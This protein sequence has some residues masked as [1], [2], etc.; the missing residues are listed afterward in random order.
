M[1]GKGRVLLP[2]LLRSGL[3]VVGA[4]FLLSSGGLLYRTFG[5]Q[6]PAWGLACYAWAG[7]LL[8]SGIARVYLS[9]PW[10]Y[11]AGIALS[12]LGLG[13]LAFGG[14]YGIP[15]AGDALLRYLGVGAPAAQEV[16]PLLGHL[17]RLAPW[18]MGLTLLLGA[19][20]AAQPWLTRFP[21]PDAEDGARS[22]LQDPAQ[23]LK[24]SALL[25]G[26][27]FYL[28]HADGLVLAWTGS[29]VGSLQAPAY[30]YAVAQVMAQGVAYVGRG[31]WR[32]AVTA[33]IRGYSLLL[34]TA[35]LLG[36][37]PRLLGDMG[38]GTLLA[39]ALR[40][41]GPYLLHLA[42]LG[43]WA[44]GYLGLVTSYRVL[45]ALL[46]TPGRPALYAR[47]GRDR[48][49]P[50]PALRRAALTSAAAFLT[51]HPGGFLSLG[52]GVD[53]SFLKPRVYGAAGL[54]L[55]SGWA[56]LLSLREWTRVPRVLFSSGAWG[57]LTYALLNDLPGIAERIGA[58]PGLAGLAR[59]LAPYAAHTAT[60]DLWATA[61]ILVV[62]VYRAAE[63]YVV[64]RLE[65]AAPTRPKKITA[66]SG[67]LLLRPQRLAIASPVKALV[68][69]ALRAAGVYLLLPSEGYLDLAWGL[70]LGFLQ[71]PLYVFLA[72][73]LAGGMSSFFGRRLWRYAS[74][75]ALQGVAWGQLWF[76][77]LRDIPSVLEALARS[78]S[79]APLG[80][81]LGPYLG[82]LTPLAPWALAYVL[83]T[84]AYCATALYWNR[85]AF[86][87][88]Y[89]RLG[90]QEDAPVRALATS[91]LAAVSTY[92][93]LSPSGL[94][95]L[96]YGL[97]FSFLAA[98]LY[99]ATAVLLLAR[100]VHILGSGLWKVALAEFFTWS[101]LAG[102][103]YF[104]F[105]SLGRIGA[106]LS[107][108]PPFTLAGEAALPY[109]AAVQR[110]D[111]WA[112]GGLE[113]LAVYRG[114]AVYWSQPQYAQFRPLVQA[115][116]FLLL[117]GMVWGAFV[118][119]AALGPL[120]PGLGAIAFGA[121][122]AVA[123]GHLARYAAGVSDPLA[124]ALGGWASASAFRNANVGAFLVL[125]A[126][127]LRRALYSA[128]LYAPLLEWVVVAAIC[129]Y[130]IRRTHK[131]LASQDARPP[132]PPAWP[133]W[134]RHHQEV[135]AVPDAPLQNALRAQEL[136]LQEGFPVGLIVRLI[137]ALG[138]NGVPPER[139]TAVI[140]P[141]ADYGEP[142]FNPLW[143]L[144]VRLHPHGR[145]K[146]ARRVAEHRAA[147]YRRVQ[148][149]LEEALT[150]ARYA[151]PFPGSNGDEFR[152]QA[153]ASFIGGDQKAGL[154]TV[155]ALESWRRGA[156]RG[157]MDLLLLPVLVYQDA[158]VPWYALPWTRL[159][160]AG[161][162]VSQ[163]QALVDTLRAHRERQGLL[164]VLTGQTA[165]ETPQSSREATERAGV[166]T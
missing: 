78:P 163:R 98:P 66:L 99:A 5:V 51:F 81:A 29:Y 141:L 49:R 53:L 142:R 65:T 59:T 26:L 17:S 140:G 48:E 15:A 67:I 95:H 162:I 28:F 18:V 136:F 24:Q 13:M 71:G 27:A 2:G 139:I 101:A 31:P 62:A 91:A 86:R 42:R 150:D 96:W 143:L 63:P 122:A 166:T 102:L 133:T 129:L 111:L 119:L 148:R 20:R 112:G 46:V 47:L 132:L 34:V 117:A 164:Q 130:V 147:A 116:T 79:L 4:Y 157:R 127:F 154:V 89:S 128:F 159:R 107:A 105:H 73:H 6:V 21:K 45:A 52:P 137:I 23:S 72:L 160:L 50:V 165:K 32:R 76:L 138:D 16:L 93:V 70:D 39:E 54:F 41:T 146:V 114:S 43:P 109:L 84:T 9:Q 85:P 30:L 37:M 94:L 118:S 131:H 144:G 19:Y 11:A 57:L 1:R 22:P 90:S 134:E 38:E 103:Y 126:V 161:T 83:L 56:G 44:A 88:A 68:W 80:G 8:A 77:L 115:T 108:T 120:Y 156:S 135:T 82:L 14:L 12:R 158:A 106:E 25:A 33:G 124:R 151:P 110:L 35:L 36:G 58:T 55:L 100:L 87:W 69:A 145:Q 40:P 149:L 10:A 74:L 155:L 92:S 123:L 104:L 64:P 61:L 113:L 7:L 125:Y 152:R 97:G 75:I 60:L 3:L 121:L 153:E